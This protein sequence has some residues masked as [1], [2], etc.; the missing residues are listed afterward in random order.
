MI[1]ESEIVNESKFLSFDDYK[2]IVESTNAKVSDL[3]NHFLMLL[4]LSN[5]T[6]INDSSDAKSKFEPIMRLVYTVS[7]DY[8]TNNG[9][10][11]KKKIKNLDIESYPSKIDF[12]LIEEYLK[13]AKKIN[14]DQV[15]QKEIKKIKRILKKETQ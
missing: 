5:N 4:K 2:L 3:Y 10:N 1:K 12:K 7:F 15:L 14:N 9:A 11:D 13:V 6:N 8:D